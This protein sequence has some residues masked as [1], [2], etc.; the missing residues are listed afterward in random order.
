MPRV[1]LAVVLAVSMAVS[2]RAITYGTPDGNAH[3]NVGL[4]VGFVSE[5]QVLICSGTLVSPMIFLTAGHCVQPLQQGSLPT[6]VT[7]KSEPPF[8]GTLIPGSPIAHP[9]LFQS[10]PDTADIGVV[11]FETPV[12]GIEPAAVPNEGFLDS[13]AVR[14]GLNNVYFTHVGYG[15]Q[16]VRPFPMF[17]LVRYSGVSSLINLRN[18]FTD[19]FNLQTT[20]NPGGGRS[21]VCFGDSGGPAFFRDTDL[22]V[23]VHSFV[24]NRNCKGTGLSY[25][26]DSPTALSFLAGFGVFPSTS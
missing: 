8:G 23:A 7:F 10:F 3:P 15:V 17:D 11:V 13:L 16:S 22:V 20:A 21:G 12:V 26:I 1:S 9:S 2:M 19:G 14:R 25:R 18:A 5:T 24:L 6:F 4:L